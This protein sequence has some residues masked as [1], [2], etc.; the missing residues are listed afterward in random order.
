MCVT[1]QVELAEIRNRFG[2]PAGRHFARAHE[3]PEGLKHFD[4]HEVRRMELAFVPKE[5]RL[6]S[7]AKRGLQE[8]FEQG[9]RVDHDH[10]DSRASRITTAAGVFNVTRLRP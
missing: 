2:G 6:D 7:S 8:K 1:E 3:P 4:V 5:P 10:A 9:R